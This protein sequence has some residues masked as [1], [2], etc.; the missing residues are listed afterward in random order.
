M[1]FRPLLG[2]LAALVT[3]ALVVLPGAAPAVG[4]GQ[5]RCEPRFESAPCPDLPAPLRIPTAR[6]GFLVVPE[7]RSRPEGRTIRLAVMIVPAVSTQP[8]PDPIVHLTGGPGGKAIEG[9]RLAAEAL[10]NSRIASI[11]GVGHFVAPESRCAQ[12]VIASFLLRPDAPDSSCV[13]TLRP[14]AFVTP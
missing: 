6:C 1:R 7:N 9:R 12:A 4:S 3:S 2:A 5:A 10:P 14:P 11:P 13:A 8:A